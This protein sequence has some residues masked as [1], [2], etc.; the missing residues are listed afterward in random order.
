M[1][2]PNHNSFTNQKDAEYNLR[3]KVSS[4]DSI[5]AV[6]R[7]LDEVLRDLEMNSNDLNIASIKDTP[8]GIELPITVQTPA[9]ISSS[10]FL[11]SNQSLNKTNSSEFI[12]GHN[13]P[14]RQ[15][16]VSTYEYCQECYDND[17]N[18]TNCKSRKQIQHDHYEPQLYTQNLKISE[19]SNPEV[20]QSYYTSST[21]LN[22]I[23]ETSGK[24]PIAVRVNKNVV[25]SG[26]QMVK[27]L[28][29]PRMSVEKTL[30][31]NSN[32]RSRSIPTHSE[33]MSK[34][35]GKPPVPPQ[36]STLGRPRKIETS[37]IT[38]NTNGRSSNCKYSKQAPIASDLCELTI[39]E[40]DIYKSNSTSNASK[41]AY[42]QFK[43]ID[44][45][46]SNSST[47]SGISSMKQ[48]STID[49][50][51]EIIVNKDH[52]FGDFGFSISDSLYGKGIYINKVRSNSI[53][54]YLKPYTQIYQVCII[55]CF[56]AF[57]NS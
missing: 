53:N 23:P 50:R 4:L 25:Y 52:R 1:N 9:K 48:N 41:L 57:K 51:V 56:K 42:S 35:D 54:P 21:K 37:S 43:D 11:N 19:N 26:R 15:N 22:P 17:P 33:E 45:T 32:Q 18:H 5:N 24:P 55:L 7:E 38:L 2:I 30:K 47:T 28:N 20:N 12:S 10:S 31:V 14:R 46:S 44:A 40:G 16:I 8:T 6:E 13:R 3:K 49:D 39:D 29:G 27:P 34:E 36:N